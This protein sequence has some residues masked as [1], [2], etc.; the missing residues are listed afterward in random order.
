VQVY[1]IE[2]TPLSPAMSK[3]VGCGEL[4]LFFRGQLIYKRWLATGQEHVFHAGE[5]L[6]QFAAENRGNRGD[7]YYA[8]TTINHYR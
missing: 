4:Y 6:T 2:P 1:T 7:G 3:W 8:R 5:G